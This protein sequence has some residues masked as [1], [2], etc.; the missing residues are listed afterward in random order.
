MVMGIRNCRATWRLLVLF[1]FLAERFPS[2]EAGPVVGNG[3]ERR[4]QR[5]KNREALEIMKG[6]TCAPT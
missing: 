1:V 5:G 4:S 2:F 6:M 3:G